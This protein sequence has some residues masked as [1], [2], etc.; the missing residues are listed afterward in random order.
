MTDLKAKIVERIGEVKSSI[1]V[2][3]Q[4]DNVSLEESREAQETLKC[5]FR[6]A[7]P[8]PSE[9]DKAEFQRLM[10]LAEL[11]YL[12]DELERLQ[13]TMGTR[14]VKVTTRYV[15]TNE[16]LASPAGFHPDERVFKAP[17][18]ALYV[19]EIPTTLPSNKGKIMCFDM[20][21]V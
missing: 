21:R 7:I 4:I 20:E 17:G 19:D 3:E 16:R 10:D 8:A 5:M 11:S 9:A 15:V 6:N 1:A 2:L 12:H 18:W 14:L 13:V